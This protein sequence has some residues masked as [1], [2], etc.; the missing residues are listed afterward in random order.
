[1]LSG[2]SG[3]LGNFDRCKKESNSEIVL[4]EKCFKDEKIPAG[5]KSFYKFDLKSD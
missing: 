2:S 3:P 1:M 5:E 4:Y